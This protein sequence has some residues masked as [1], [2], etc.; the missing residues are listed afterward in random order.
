[1]KVTIVPHFSAIF[2]LHFAE[3]VEI[4]LTVTSGTCSYVYACAHCHLQVNG[5]LSL[6]E[7]K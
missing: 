5:Y 4:C 6:S 7:A 2:V 1:M 3:P